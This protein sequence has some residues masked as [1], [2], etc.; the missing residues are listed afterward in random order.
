ASMWFS[1]LSANS[2][3]SHGVCKRAPFIV[4]LSTRTL[5]TLSVDIAVTPPGLKEEV[6]PSST[7][8]IVFEFLKDTS[9]F[10]QGTHSR[11]GYVFSGV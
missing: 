9:A 5:I 11:S 10:G 7:E 8:Q 2:A 6:T 1:I 3:A 4:N